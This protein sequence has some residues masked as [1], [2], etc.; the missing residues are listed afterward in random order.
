MT[1]RAGVDPDVPKDTAVK[2]QDQERLIV[3]TPT[4]VT[5]FSLEQKIIQR[6]T[7]AFGGN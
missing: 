5:E 2:A 7:L 6:K 3:S 1:L 4:A